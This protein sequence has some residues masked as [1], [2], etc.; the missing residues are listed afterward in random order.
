MSA[1]IGKVVSLDGKFLA[2]ASDESIREISHGDEIHE[3]EVI[4]GNSTN[5]EIDS[6][7][8][9]LD[10]GTDIVVQG[11]ETQLFDASLFD[12]IFSENETVSSFET[13]SNM[14]NGN[15][16][17][18]IT[19]DDIDDTEDVETEAGEDAAET[20]ELGEGKFAEHNAAITDINAEADS[21]D[22]QRTD[23]VNSDETLDDKQNSS[24]LDVNRVFA[25]NENSEN[26]AN[27]K[28]AQD[29]VD[30]KAAQDVSD[31]KAAGDEEDEE[32]DK[33]AQD[34]ADAARAALIS[35]NTKVVQAE[36]DVNDA[37]I[38]TVTPETA[39]ITEDSTN[40]GLKIATISASDEDNDVTLTLSDTTNYVIVGNEVQ[41]T[42]AGADL[43][44]LGSDL[45][46]F[47]VDANG[48]TSNVVNP[49]DTTDVNDV[50]IASNES[51]TINEDTAYTLTTNDFGYA[52]EDG[53]S[54]HS[55]KITD[56]PDS[57]VITLN[58]T[59]I[60]LEDEISVND[61][62][63]GNLVFTPA[64]NSSD[65]I[66]FDFKVSDNGV[67]WSN[68]A[69]T[70]ISV[71]AEADSPNLSMSVGDPEAV[72]I[73][74][75]TDGGRNANNVEALDYAS[76]LTAQ[77]GNNGTAGN[78]VFKNINKSDFDF[79]TDTSDKIMVV[80]GQTNGTNGNHTTIDMGDGGDNVLV[81]TN[82][83]PDNNCDIIFADDGHNIVVLPITKSEYEANI[84]DYNIVNA[85]AIFFSGSSDSIGDASSI[86][87]GYTYDITIDA[88]L[89]DTDGSETLG[90]I[91]VDNLPSGA[92]IS[93]LSVDA[94]GN[95]VATVSS[96]SELDASALNSM[97]ASVT[98]TE[99]NGDSSTATSSAQIEIDGTASAETVDGTSADEVIDAKEG[100]D[101]INAGAGDDNIVLDVNDT[102]ID[103]GEGLDTLLIS[104]GMDIDLSAL[105]D[106]ISNIEVIDLGEGSQNITSLSIEDVLNITDTDNILRIDG[107][108]SDTID[109]DTEWTLGGFK[110][111]AETGATYQEVTGVEDG[112]SITLEINTDIVID[113]G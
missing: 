81:F 45:P 84:S 9:T 75:D 97:T 13:I 87:A 77:N 98:A 96:S 28:A 78:L 41:L 11:D 63:D 38:I 44:N 100:A 60:S 82:H 34:A 46:N 70:S 24:S 106:N 68:E 79:D 22:F 93:E 99:A 113:Q 65:D 37:A 76:A 19:D 58:G 17:I 66:S 86:I 27:K 16:E 111:D 7:I 105:D 25:S 3:G 91:S 108:D 92:T 107:D 12:E 74:F 83:S 53:N 14:L 1:V 10:N 21:V 20:S 73:D 51:I 95:T 102:S 57:G 90:A 2:K 36:V 52:D 59:A 49:V 89:S 5:S 104:D 56:L 23:E 29:A 35:A 67:E 43:V 110:T 55:V 4:T 72:L 48:V 42:Q 103:G 69:T 18:D 101:T 31:A 54:M 40:A 85:D 32:N 33:A 30:A 94:D 112:Q 64:T 39:T 26:A 6:V 88:S 62:T 50:S 71:S 47:T 109:L 8:V 80:T 15:E 61:I